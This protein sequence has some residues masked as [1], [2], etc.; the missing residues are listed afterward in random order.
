MIGIHNERVV[1]ENLDKKTHDSGVNKNRQ[2]F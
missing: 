2:A 1:V